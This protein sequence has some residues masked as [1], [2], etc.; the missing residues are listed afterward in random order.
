MENVGGND[1][2]SDNFDNDMDGPVD[3]ADPDCAN[4]PPCS[5]AAPVMSA[6][7]TILMTVLLSLVGLL[8][9]AR[10]RQRSQF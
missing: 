10:S 5:T 7:A 9:M 8:G 4:I 2:C 1:N 3:C 6:P